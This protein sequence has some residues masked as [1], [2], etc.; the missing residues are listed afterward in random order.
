MKKII[1]LLLAAGAFGSA[2]AQT[3]QED[4]RRVI[5]GGKNKSSR[6]TDRNSDSRDVVLGGDDRRV[7][8]GE[9]G[10][11]YPSGSREASID[12]I[13]RQYDAKIQSIR[14]NRNLTA[15]EKE[16]IIRDLNNERNRQI[17]A[18]SS[19][20]DRYE[21]RDN[22]R[23]DDDDDRRYKK[24]KRYKGNNGNHYGWKKGKGN[25]HRNRRD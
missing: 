6:T 16:R 2:V 21:R 17:R 8:Y 23:Y 3:A 14:N 24:N 12:G 19:R 13:N 10:N 11:R 4:A 1:T 25:K 7:V 18:I 5:L 9:S 15:A 20:N 22:S